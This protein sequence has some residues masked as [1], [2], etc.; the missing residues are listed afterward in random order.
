[1]CVKVES[2]NFIKKIWNIKFWNIIII[3]IH[4]YPK[5]FF[6]LR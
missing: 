2:I 3:I 1:M 5:L 6:M 4:Y